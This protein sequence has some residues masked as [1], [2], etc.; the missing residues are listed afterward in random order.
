MDPLSL[1][2]GFLVGAFTGAAGAY[3]ADKY[4][5]KR[6]TKELKTKEDELWEEVLNRFP[7]LITEMAKDFKNPDNSGVRKFFVKSSTTT[8]NSGE[9]SFEY[10]TDVHPNIG[11]AMFYLADI[12]YIEDITS[13]NCPIYRMYEHFVDRLK[14]I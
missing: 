13:G 3:L 9:R 6:R 12:G 8:V 14:R 4:T 7:Q 2:I 11:A 1:L 5:D 10:H